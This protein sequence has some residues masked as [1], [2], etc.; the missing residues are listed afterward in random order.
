MNG[1]FSG[2]ALRSR[3]APM[4]ACLLLAYLK[5]RHGCCARVLVNIPVLAPPIEHQIP[6][7]PPSAPFLQDWQP[8]AARARHARGPRQR[9]RYPRQHPRWA[10][11]PGE[12]F[13][14][15]HPGSA[16][17]PPYSGRVRVVAWG[18]GA[19]FEKVWGKCGESVCGLPNMF[20]HPVLGGE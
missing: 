17:P 11:S 9:R 2:S 18:W 10:S 12:P 8:F 19:P 7:F 16:E 13:L 3:F 6:P 5:S 20:S 4:A 1:A 15:P 14:P